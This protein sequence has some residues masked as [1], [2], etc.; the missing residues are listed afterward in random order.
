MN[1]KYS[2]ITS[3]PV[4]YRRCR[5]FD[6]QRDRGLLVKLNLLG[7]FLLAAIIFLLSQYNLLF[8]RVS[9]FGLP[10]SGDILSLLGL[11]PLVIVLNVILHE[12]AHGIFFWVITGSAPKVGIGLGYAYA[13]APGF[14]IPRSR[15][16]L[17]ALA[18]V[19][20]LTALALALIPFL[21]GLLLFWVNI[22]TI[23]NFT[24]SVGDLWVVGW[25]IA[26]PGTAL[27][28]DFGDRIE[29]YEPVEKA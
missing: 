21:S 27:V 16:F 20:I 10:D 13:A 24:G 11:L 14:Y 1:A 4:N 15:Y 9:F 25:L 12:A 18:P 7:L 3:L 6:I 2:T 29:I 26:K 23:M 5:V 8:R 19:V 28:Q 17:T 22:F